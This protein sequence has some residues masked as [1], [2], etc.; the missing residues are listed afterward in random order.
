MPAIRI[1]TVRPSLPHLLSPRWRRHQPSQATEELRPQEQPH[2]RQ[3]GKHHDDGGKSQLR[4]EEVKLEKLQNK[5][6]EQNGIRLELKSRIE[7]AEHRVQA[8]RDFRDSCRQRDREEQYHEWEAGREL[9]RQRQQRRR[10]REQERQLERQR[11][12][13]RRDSEK[14]FFKQKALLMSNSSHK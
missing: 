6:D 5:Y 7:R 14:D 2:G 12:Q 10:D 13:Q 3:K 8:A 1:A 11:Q 4:K 9:I